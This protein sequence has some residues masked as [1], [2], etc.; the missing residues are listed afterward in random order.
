[1]A[2]ARTLSSSKLDH[3]GLSL[4]VEPSLDRSPDTTTAQA[5]DNPRKSAKY[6][7]LDHIKSSGE[8]GWCNGDEV[9]GIHANPGSRIESLEGVTE[10]LEK[11]KLEPIAVI[12]LGC[13]LPQDAA[14]PEAFWRMLVEARSAMTEVPKD[15]FDIDAFYDGNSNR[16][17]M[18]R[19][20]SLFA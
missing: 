16:P 20:R 3:I 11:D 6:H 8:Q 13:R 19:N 9:N 1:M 14:S 18:V 17:G 5:S 2:P 10:D 7:H 12:G 15:R 4:K